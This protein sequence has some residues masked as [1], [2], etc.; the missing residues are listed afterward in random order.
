MSGKY[1]RPFDEEETGCAVLFVSS[2][3]AGKV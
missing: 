3:G 2:R 1:F